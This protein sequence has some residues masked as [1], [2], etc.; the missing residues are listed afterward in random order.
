MGDL[1]YDSVNIPLQDGGMGVAMTARAIPDYHYDSETRNKILDET[2]KFIAM[3]GSGS[4]SMRE[5]AKAVG[6]QSGSIYHYYTSK[7]DLMKDI[8]SRLE[9]GYRHYFD[10]LT[11]ENEKAGTLEE[12]MDNM[13]NKELVEMLDPMVCLGMS[14]ALREEHNNGF[15]RQIVFDLFFR[16]SIACM[17]TAFD[18]LAEKGLIPPG[19]TK[20]IATTLMFCVLICNEIRIQEYN[21]VDT[22]ID[23]AEFF[24]GLRKILTIALTFGAKDFVSG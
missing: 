17:Q 4:V 8:L 16:H 13:F 14:I 6:I 3:K 9:N 7:D 2:L 20:T 18:R 10:W 5:I 24:N 12:V 19:D 1:L 15:A 11:G 23:R 22:P 21:G